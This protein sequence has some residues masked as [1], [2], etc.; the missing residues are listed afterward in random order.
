MILDPR[1]SHEGMGGLRPKDYWIRDQIM[2]FVIM[3]RRF[4]S[5]FLSCLHYVLPIP[6]S[7]CLLY[8]FDYLNSISIYRLL[9]TSQPYIEIEYGK[10][11]FKNKIFLT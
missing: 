5:L 4:F 7:L 6:F 1:P 8:C 11:T 10:M 3:T 2:A 9:R